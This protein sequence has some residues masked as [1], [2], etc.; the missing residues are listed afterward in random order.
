MKVYTIP[1][2]VIRWRLIL[3]EY[4]PEFIYI[5]CSKTIAA[6]AW[7]RLNEVDTN[8]PIKPNMSSLAAHF[9]LARKRRYFTSS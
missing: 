6:D 2:R 3:K 1:K 5:Q 4:N 8:D 7:S 9:S